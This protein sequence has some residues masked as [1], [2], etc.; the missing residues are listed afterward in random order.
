MD[1]PLPPPP[2]PPSHQFWVGVISNWQSSPKI[3]DKSG[4]SI[5]SCDSN[6]EIHPVLQ[7]IQKPIVKAD[8]APPTNSLPHNSTPSFTAAD[9][10]VKSEPTPPN[11]APSSD[12]DT[13]FKIPA[14]KVKSER[15]SQNSTPSAKVKTE[16]TPKGVKVKGEKRSNQSNGSETPTVR[17]PFISCDHVM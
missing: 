13:K 16:K 12:S 9:A 1:N 3:V 4:C 17:I 15:P 2:P 14:L 8:P 6:E 11:P 10:T 7:D 5:R